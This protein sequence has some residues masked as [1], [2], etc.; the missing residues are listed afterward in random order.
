M[1]IDRKDFKPKLYKLR[2]DLNKIKQKGFSDGEED[3][4]TLEDNHGV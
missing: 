2:D 4:D 3:N 1:K